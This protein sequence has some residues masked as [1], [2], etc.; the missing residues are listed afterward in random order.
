M[1][2]EV[3]NSHKSSHRFTRFSYK[4]NLSKSSGIEIISPVVIDE[5]C[6][7]NTCCYQEKY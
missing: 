2:S 1:Q 5:S 7:Y 6:T 3:Q 4:F